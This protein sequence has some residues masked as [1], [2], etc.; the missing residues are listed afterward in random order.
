MFKYLR[1]THTVGDL[2]TQPHLSISNM[3]AFHSAYH[4][5]DKN[6]LVLDNTAAVTMKIRVIEDEEF[7]HMMI[8]TRVLLRPTRTNILD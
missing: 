3:H 6:R 8:I 2:A 1:P 5:T 4:P 7:H